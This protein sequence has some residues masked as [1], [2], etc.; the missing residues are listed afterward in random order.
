MNDIQRVL[1]SAARRL[2]F[3]NFL[4]GLVCALII[5]LSAAL[6]ARLAQQ[7][8]VFDLRWKLVAI[9]APVGCLLVA[10]V[11]AF[12][13]RPSS[14]KVALKVDE[15]ANLREAISTA[16]YVGNSDEAWA[17]ATVESAAVSAR[18]VEIRRAVPIQSPRPWPLLLGL[19]LAFA[20]VYIAL[21]KLDLFKRSD[22]LAVSDEKK[23]EAIKLISDDKEFKAKIEQMTSKLGLEKSNDPEDVSKPAPTD[24]DAIR[25][26][27]IKQLTKLSEQL[28]NKLQSDQ[29][30]KL[31]ATKQALQT[32]KPQGA[33]TQ[34]LTKA[35]NAGNFSQAKQ[36]LEALKNK[37]QNGQLTPSEQQAAVEQMKKIAEEINKAAQN[38]SEL[39]K[40]LEQAGIDKKL[41][42]NPEALKKALEQ[43]KDLSQ[44]KKDELQKQSEASKQASE[45][46][47]Q[48]AE[49]INKMAAACEKPGNKPGDKGQ[50]GQKGQNGEKGQQG[51][52][53]QKMEGASQLSDQLSEMEQISQE[54]QTAEAAMS[55]CNSQMGKMG[56]G[57]GKCNGMGEGLEYSNGNGKWS[58]GE[59]TESR[60][61]GRGGPGRA[62]GGSAGE[63]PADF[64]TSKRVDNKNQ[65]G[66]GPIVASRLVEG[67][68]VLN[69]STAEFET[70]VSVAT[71]EA[72]EEIENKVIPRDRHEAVKSYFG[73][74]KKTADDKSRKAAPAGSGNAPAAPAAKD[75]K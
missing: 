68:A 43:N 29:A 58:E 66:K 28:N 69:D 1:R 40:K 13:V 54:M 75:A 42:E 15:G 67:E 14:K 34:E 20:V 36:E 71:G 9:W 35:M 73:R 17:R 26:S 55:E 30:M 19:A 64:N 49:S 37:L 70:A 21:P 31:E 74:L 50:Q 38:K 23:L 61:S 45:S 72:S 46:L 27:A 39:A 4:F 6:L 53:G 44:E 32:I 48:M 12:V 5:A 3:N 63:S 22:T 62:S 7:T 47:S 57:Q 51:E 18:R 24:P 16:L 25:R 52:Q 2:G 33:E 65:T 59:L 8:I 10:A 60:G 56:E 41:A 11:Y